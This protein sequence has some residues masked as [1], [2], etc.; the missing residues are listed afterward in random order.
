VLTLTTCEGSCY[1][2][3]PSVIL[4]TRYYLRGPKIQASNPLQERLLRD[5]IEDG[6]HWIWGGAKHRFGYGLL[7]W[8]E[9]TSLVHR[10][11]WSAWI[12]PIPDGKFV[13]HRCDIPPCFRIRHL[14]LG[15]HLENM[16]DM[17][18]KGRARGRERIVD[19]PDPFSPFWYTSVLNL[20]E[21]DE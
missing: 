14:F 5:L 19:D 18:R 2:G 13:L 11:A 17:S 1:L 20:D 4:M 9:H 16:Q 6:P 7:S 8:R 21:M 12:G 15:T 3:Y 10:L